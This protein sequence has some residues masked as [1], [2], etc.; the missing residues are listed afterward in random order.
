VGIEECERYDVVAAAG[1]R[2]AAEL[3]A[4]L[5]RE[6]PV[7]PQ[8]TNPDR[9]HPGKPE[10]GLAAGVLFVGNSRGQRRP[11]VE[12]ALEAGLDLSV[13][14]AGWEGTPVEQALRA[15]HLPNELVPA[16]YRSAGIVLNDHWPDMAERGIVSN[17]ILDAVASGAVVVTDEAA[18]IE[19][20]VG[21]AVTVVSGREGLVAA[22]SAIRKDPAAYEARALAGSERVRQDHTFDAR[23]RT[24]V[25]QLAPL[26]EGWGG[27]PGGAPD[28]G[29]LDEAADDG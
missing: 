13:Y 16:A 3:G 17:R 23:A 7:L 27:I 1:A 15:D 6:L 12:W 28:W 14:G 11:I 26:L 21:D 20:L 29:R 2:F 18:G 8:A 25:G 22:V 24:I 10:A 4:K 5:G 19:E 9:F